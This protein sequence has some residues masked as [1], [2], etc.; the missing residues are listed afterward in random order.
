MRIDKPRL[1]DWTTALLQSW[2]Y[3]HDD[4]EYVADTLVDANLRAIDSHGVIRLGIYRARIE[5]DLVRPAAVP[6]VELSGAVARISAN[7]APGQIAARTAVDA[8]DKLSSEYGVATA[9]VHGSS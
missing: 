5:K 9:V 2:G 6:T 7:R 1:Q 4:A 8:I 3:S